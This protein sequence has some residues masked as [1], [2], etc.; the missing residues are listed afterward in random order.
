MKC[1][2]CSEEYDNSFGACPFC[3][4]LNPGTSHDNDDSAQAE[5]A[6]L[7]EE[8]TAA[9][10]N[11]QPTESEGYNDNYGETQNETAQQP[12]ELDSNAIED[13]FGNGYTPQEAAPA[14]SILKNKKAIIIGGAIGLVVIIGIIVAIIFGTG[15]ASNNKQ[16]LSSS[17]TGITATNPDGTPVVNSTNPDGTPIEYAT[18][19]D[20]TVATDPQ[21]NPVVITN[22]NTN[23]SSNSSSNSSATSSGNDS[24]ASSKADDSSSKPNDTSSAAASGG[25]ST[26]TPSSN[27]GDS[28][29]TVEINGQSFKVGDKVKISFYINGVS[30]SVAGINST[31]NYNSS[32]L[33]YEE[34]SIAL[35]NLPGCVYNTSLDNQI[36]FNASNVTSG[37]DFSGE[38]LLLSASFT[39]NDTSATADTVSINLVELLDQDTN[40]INSDEYTTNIVIEK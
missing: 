18:N 5:P 19:A 40:D 1:P 22:P 35:P 13:N 20:G 11:E 2:K 26:A 4:T 9:G 16:N 30:K 32:L 14:N 7:S 27:S 8:S 34:D 29:K 24:S 21:G 10:S 28:D 36:L 6:A 31:V 3:G 33:T 39:I 25:S 38:T 12:D 15:G 37:F 17:A 23:G